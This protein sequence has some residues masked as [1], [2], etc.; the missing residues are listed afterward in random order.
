VSNRPNRFA[1]R[2]WGGRR[3]PSERSLDRSPGRAS[4]R[5]TFSDT[6]PGIVCGRNQRGHNN[7][8]SYHRWFQVGFRQL[9]G[10][11][12]GRAVLPIGNI[13]LVIVLVIYYRRLPHRRCLDHGRGAPRKSAA[14][15]SSKSSERRGIEVH[16]TPSNLW[17]WRRCSG[18][19]GKCCRKRRGC[20]FAAPLHR[21]GS[22][23]RQTGTR[24]VRRCALD[25]RVA[26]S[27]RRGSD[28]CRRINGHCSWVGR[29]RLCVCDLLA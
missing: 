15:D 1:S 25:R 11:L 8:G 9:P 12:G 19:R 14:R 10:W 27:R 22:L 21:H 4:Q 3:R 16:R 18:S 17:S 29:C 24:F 26:A 28:C 13:R 20:P 7:R 6:R 23:R 2:A 5:C